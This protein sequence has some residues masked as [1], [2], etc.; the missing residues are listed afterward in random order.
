MNSNS[1]ITERGQ[2]TVPKKLR[3]RLGL[4]PGTVVTFVSSHKGILIRKADNRADPFK[5]IFGVV[6]DGLRTDDYLRKTRGNVE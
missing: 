1:V 3:D 5:E 2:V 6:K 4:K